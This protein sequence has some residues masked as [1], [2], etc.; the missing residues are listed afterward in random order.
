MLFL[1]IVVLSILAFD[2][3]KALWFTDPATGTTTFGIG[4]GT[5]VLAVNAVLLGGYLF[6][7]HSM[8]HMAGGCVDQLSRAPL[9][10]KAYDCVSCLNRRHMAWA[11]GSL[12]S[13]G[14]ADLYV[15]LCSMGM[16]SDL[17]II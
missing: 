11:W 6:G 14:F 4:V 7:C 13:V 5:I 10:V 17:R 1:A 8:R 9:G 16:W 12:F 3:W 2:V 15:R